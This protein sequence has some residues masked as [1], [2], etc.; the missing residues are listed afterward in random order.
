[1][2]LQLAYWICLL[3]YIVLGAVPIVRGKDWSGAGNSLLVILLFLIL[4]WAEFGA[5]LSKHG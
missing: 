3:L 5:P 4:G 2:S 1:M